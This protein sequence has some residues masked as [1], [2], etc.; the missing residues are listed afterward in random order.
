MYMTEIINLQF[1]IGGLTLKRSAME[2]NTS[3]V[4]GLFC[5]ACVSFNEILFYLVLYGC[6][7]IPSD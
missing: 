4:C 1:A 7:L 3:E 2:E 5:S 6:E